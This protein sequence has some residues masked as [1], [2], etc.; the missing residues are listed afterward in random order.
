MRDRLRGHSVRRRRGRGA[1]KDTM[2]ML[3]TWRSSGDDAGEAVVEGGLV[4]ERRCRGGRAAAARPRH[5]RRNARRRRWLQRPHTWPCKHATLAGKSP[6][7]AFR[8][9]NNHGVTTAI[10]F[11]EPDV[12]V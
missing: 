3:K 9:R 12:T 4:A 8:P 6:S 5:R 1:A 11:R 2:W 10:Y 7:G